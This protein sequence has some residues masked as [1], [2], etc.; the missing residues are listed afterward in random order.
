MESKERGVMR[1]AGVCLSAIFPLILSRF[2]ARFF[3]S[4]FFLLFLYALFT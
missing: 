4:F 1:E 3:L 2:V